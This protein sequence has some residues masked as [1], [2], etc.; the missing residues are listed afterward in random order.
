MT[1]KRVLVVD[2]EA[3]L[4]MTL[5]G[6]LELE[7]FEVAEADSASAALELLSSRTFDLVLSDIRMPGMNGVELFRRIRLQHDAVPV[8]LMTAFEI[9]D[10]ITAALEEGAYAILPKPFDIARLV[11]T[12]KQ[13][14]SAPVVLVVD[15][16]AQ[17]ATSMVSALSASGIT[18]R[19]AT[20]AG[21]AEALVQ[22]ENVDLCIVDLVMP[23]V[24][25]PVL[26]RRLKA[27]RP[28]VVIIAISGK[29]VPELMRQAAGLGTHTFLTKPFDVRV[30]IRSIA[31]AR[32]AA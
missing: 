8:V 29:D 11:K 23:D 21:E 7:G 25:G 18:A 15:D 5:A 26:A 20:T 30:L 27:V 19:A 2:D 1:A 17:V 16:E 9:E 4:R 3:G 32:S 14:T 22:Q 13:A 28:D 10:V 31:S 6:N 24:P 12:L